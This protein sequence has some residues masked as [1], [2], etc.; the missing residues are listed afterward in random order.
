MLRNQKTM[1]SIF[2][3]I[4]NIFR[5]DQ[6]ANQIKFSG[7]RKMTLLLS[8]FV[9]FTMQ[10]QAQ[11]LEARLIKNKWAL[12]S[13]IQ[14]EGMKFDTLFTA[15]NCEAEYIQFNADG[16][17]KDTNLKRLLRFSVSVDS[18]VT[19]KKSSGIVHKKSRIS[20]IDEDK[21]TLIDVNRGR[22]LFFIETYTRCEG[23]SEGI[24]KDSRNLV[25]IKKQ[26]GLFVGIKQWD[27]SVFELGLSWRKD[28]WRKNSLYKSI[29]INTDPSNDIFGAS[30]SLFAQDY[31]IY[32]AGITAYTDFD[33][34]QIGLRP[35]AGVTGKAFG[36]F[37]KNIQLFY[38][39][40]FP[41]IGE[42]IDQVSNNFI[43]LRINFPLKKNSNQERVI[44]LDTP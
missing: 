8:L 32:G 12:T 16:T 14:V 3:M 25:T 28:D 2:A 18:I 22:G 23:K 26:T 20:Y 35:I 29:S 42:K 30:A 36:E 7:L 31:L 41:V 6:A 10:S 4:K 24:A 21:L 9:L 15:L 40:N 44:H 43:T 33:E 19:L 1:K 27:A 13:Y 11:D 39:F 34:I 37:G 38:S 5:T 17:F